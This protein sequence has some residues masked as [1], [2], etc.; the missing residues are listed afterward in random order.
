MFNIDHIKGNISALTAISASYAAS[1]AKAT[2]AATKSYLTKR[3]KAS[4]LFNINPTRGYVGK[5]CRAERRNAA[6]EARLELPNLKTGTVSDVMHALYADQVHNIKTRKL[7][8]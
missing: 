4:G 5:L 1:V 7:P 8:A 3:Q 6:R 2:A